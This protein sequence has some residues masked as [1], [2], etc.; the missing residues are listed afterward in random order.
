MKLIIFI[1][2]TTFLLASVSFAH[3]R[4]VYPKNDE[5]VLVKTSISIATII[6]FPEAASLQMPIIGDQSGFR[7]EALEKGITIKPLRYSAKTNLYLFTDKKRYNFKLITIPEAQADYII[8]IK[9]TDAAPDLIWKKID[10]MVSSSNLKLTLNKVALTKDQMVLLDFNLKS[11][12]PLSIAPENFWIFQDKESK[13]IYSLFMSDKKVSDSRITQ[14]GLAISKSELK[15][16]RPIQL[17][18]KNK[19]FNLL[20]EVPREILWK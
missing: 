11:K 12:D 18:F 10:R 8:Y 2:V 3:V 14:L 4:N 16:G 17:V 15:E 6:Q 13:L 20:I 7:I 9:S 5:I 1:Y 19:N